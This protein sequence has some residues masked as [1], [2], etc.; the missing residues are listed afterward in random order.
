MGH[1]GHNTLEGYL[2]SIDVSSVVVPYDTAAPVGRVSLRYDQLSALAPMRRELASVNTEPRTILDVFAS[3]RP[4]SAL[5]VACGC[6][7][8]TRSLESFCSH[9]VAIDTAPLMSRWRER[10]CDSFVHFCRM[11]AEALAFAA[12][13]FDVV[14]GRFSLHHFLDWRLALDEMFRVSKEYV[15]VEEPVDD[16]RSE[17]KRNSAAATS[18]FLELQHDV[19]Y[20]HNPHLRREEL[21][22]EM[23]RR[24]SLLIEHVE[25]RDDSLAF[26]DYFS[27]F[28]RFARESGREDY[29]CGRLEA[30][31]RQL[32]EGRLA[33]DDTIL[34]LAR[35]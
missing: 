21:V 3:L 19:G 30:F 7:R 2:P 11:D 12:G 33:E 26:E 5:D 28:D 34:V 6:G 18:L 23:R 17:A 22:H 25:K 24:G 9:I 16:L 20:R 15:L 31:K 1:S 29:W 10:P 35:R 32:G 4:Q 13:S 8:F 27:D 14:L